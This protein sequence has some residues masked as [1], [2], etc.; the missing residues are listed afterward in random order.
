MITDMTAGPPGKILWSFTLPMLLSMAFQQLYNIVDSIIAG[1]FIGID[2][3]A[4]VGASYPITVLFLAVATGAS[5]GCSVVVSQLFGAKRYGDMKTAVSTAIISIGALAVILT[6]AGAFLCDTLMVAIQTQEDI[7]AD[8]SLYLRIYIFGMVFMFLYNASTAVFNALGDSKTPLYFLIFSSCL[9]IVLDL[10]FVA[11]LGMGVAG[12][13][14][15][16]C[17]P[18]DFLCAGGYCGSVPSKTS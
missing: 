7:F 18:G 8:A 13:A 10:L 17:R 3:L 6:I 15:N 12:V 11:V 5:A 14:G 1:N 9:N 4:A 2:A 16:L